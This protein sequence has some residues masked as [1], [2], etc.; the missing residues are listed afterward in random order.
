MTLELVPSPDSLPTQVPAKK[1]NLIIESTILPPQKTQLE[2]FTTFCTQHPNF[3]KFVF[4]CLLTSVV[5]GFCMSQLSH[6]PKE[7]NALYWSGITSM[8]AWWMPSPGSSGAGQQ[9]ANTTNKEPNR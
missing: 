7:D 3:L 8:I 4:Q 6:N 2:I 5:L 1:E 9:Q